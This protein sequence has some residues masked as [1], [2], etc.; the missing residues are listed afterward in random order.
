MPPINQL[1]PADKGEIA[2]YAPYYTDKRRKYLGLAISLYKQKN[3]EGSRNIEGGDNI[4]FVITWNVSILPA[5]IT[6]CRMQFDD[7]QELSYEIIMATYEFVNFLIDVLLNYNRTRT[8]D[9]SKTFYKKLL[10]YE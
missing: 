5:D 9:F 10:R 7:N 4:P 2:V 8:I 3:L 6:R 1:K